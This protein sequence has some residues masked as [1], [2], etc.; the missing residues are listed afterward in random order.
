[1][2]RGSTTEFQ[3]CECQMCKETFFINDK[4]EVIVCWKCG[5]SDRGSFIFE[6]DE[7][8]DDRNESAVSAS[9]KAQL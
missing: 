8:D 5:N 3:W 7:V 4:I 9:G 2:K 1:M 6:Q